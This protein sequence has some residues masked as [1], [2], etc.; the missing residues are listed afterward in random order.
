[1]VSSGLSPEFVAQR[2]YSAHGLTTLFETLAI[3][4]CK[5]LVQKTRRSKISPVYSVSVG[6]A[7]E[8]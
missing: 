1:M 3:H 5:S 2:V 7:R 6:N 8:V 4:Q